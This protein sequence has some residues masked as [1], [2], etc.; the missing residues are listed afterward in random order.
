MYGAYLPR[1]P[2]LTVSRAFPHAR[3][4]LRRYAFCRTV[5]D[6]RWLA[7]HGQMSSYTLRGPLPYTPWM[8][9]N[10]HVVPP[11]RPYLMDAVIAY[12]HRDTQS[13]APII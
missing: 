3:M 13:K 5:R 7:S 2:R 8:A 10:I 11:E 9:G 4:V 12:L 1:K 6:S